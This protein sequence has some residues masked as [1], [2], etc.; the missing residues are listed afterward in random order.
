[1]TNSSDKNSLNQIKNIEKQLNDYLSE[2]QSKCNRVK[3]VVSKQTDINDAS[4]DNFSK[5]I[6]STL[7]NFR[8]TYATYGQF[9]L[10]YVQKNAKQ[11]IVDTNF[12]NVLTRVKTL[13]ETYKGDR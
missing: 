5:G 8:Y 3:E 13:V 12:E 10:E 6:V 4:M 7:K 2:Y 9:V 11:N 1:M